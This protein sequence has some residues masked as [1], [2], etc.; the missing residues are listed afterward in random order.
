MAGIFDHS[1]IQTRM[2][3]LLQKLQFLHIWKLHNPNIT[4]LQQ[5]P[6]NRHLSG[7]TWVSRYQ[8]GKTNLDFT[9]VT[10]ASLSCTICI[11]APHPRQIT[12]SAPHH[13]VLMVRMPFLPPSK[14]HQ[15]IKG[16]IKQW[17]IVECRLCHWCAARDEQ[18]WEQNWP[19]RLLR[20]RG[21]CVC[22]CPYSVHS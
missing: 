22:V 21:V 3:L 11:S 2:L 10:M 6:F 15:S 18:N 1:Q 13:S 5:H 9:E 16:K 14:Q 4:H 7:T 8:K 20:C 19:L 17:W 12:T